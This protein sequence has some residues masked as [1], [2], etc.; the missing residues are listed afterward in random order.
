MKIHIELDWW[1]LFAAMMIPAACWLLFGTYRVARWLVR[2]AGREELL[3]TLFFVSMCLG[4]AGIGGIC[5]VI[6][7]RCEKAE[8]RKN[9]ASPATA[10]P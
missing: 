4:V 2:D 3:M 10:T 6:E 7:R 5:S 1:M 8:L 9:E